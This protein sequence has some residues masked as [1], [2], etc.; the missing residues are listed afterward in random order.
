MKTLTIC[1][2]IAFCFAACKDKEP[3]PPP[4]KAAKRGSS[5]FQAVEKPETYSQ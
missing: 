2:L 4:K 1:V 5:E 3:P